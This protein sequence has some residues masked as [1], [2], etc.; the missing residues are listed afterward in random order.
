MLETL[1]LLFY[2]R[3]INA[4]DFKTLETIITAHDVFETVGSFLKEYK[5]S[6]GKGL[7]CLH[8]WCP[9]YAMMSIWIS[10]CGTE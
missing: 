6:W 2:V 8:R 7:R 1:Q 5:I 10:M 3:H 9:S 4:G